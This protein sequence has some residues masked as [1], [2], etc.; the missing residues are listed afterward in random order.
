MFKWEP[1]VGGL[2]DVREQYLI[3]LFALVLKDKKAFAQEIHLFVELSDLKE[4]VLSLNV[5]LN[6]KVKQKRMQR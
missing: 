4:N 6:L 3:N 2:A 5:H 1:E